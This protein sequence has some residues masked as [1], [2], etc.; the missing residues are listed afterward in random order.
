MTPLSEERCRP[1]SRRRTNGARSGR[2]SVVIPATGF[3][4]AGGWTCTPGGEHW[5]GVRKPELSS[6]AD[7]LCDWAGGLLSLGPVSS[8]VPGLRSPL[9]CSGRPRTG[10]LP[11]LGAPYSPLFA[12][13]LFSSSR[14]IPGSKVPKELPVGTA[15]LGT[16]ESQATKAT[17]A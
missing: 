16:L 2:S 12:D 15:S 9:P 1:S 13:T 17:Q 3:L 4:Q 11:V 10:D 6:P 7:C 5:I 8:P 14:E